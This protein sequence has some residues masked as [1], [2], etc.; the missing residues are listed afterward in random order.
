MS[1]NPMKDWQASI[2]YWETNG[3]RSNGNGTP[4]ISNGRPN[5]SHFVGATLEF[6]ACPFGGCDGSGWYMDDDTHK[7]MTCKCQK[8][9]A[10]A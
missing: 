6:P 8:V 10:S 4:N 3:V 9:E 2:R 1:K 5:D 7:R